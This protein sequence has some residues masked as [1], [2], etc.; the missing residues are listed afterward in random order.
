MDQHE[1]KADQIVGKTL[2][3]PAAGPSIVHPAMDEQPYPP[4]IRISNL[5]GVVPS[6]GIS[7]TGTPMIGV[8]T[9]EYVRWES[10]QQRC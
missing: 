3:T 9:E 4:A 5:I 2:K 7:K 1:T 8:S 6:M 10:E